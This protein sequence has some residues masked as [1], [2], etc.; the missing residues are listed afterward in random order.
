MYHVTF[1]TRNAT[2]IGKQRFPG[3]N[4]EKPLLW[5]AALVAVALNTV[6]AECQQ[7][8]IE[9][10]TGKQIVL[11]QAD[12]EALPHTKVTTHASDTPATFEGITLNDLLGKAGIEFGQ[13][14]KDKRLASCLLVGAADRYRV[15]IALPELD[16]AFTDKQIVLFCET[17]SHW[18][19]KR[20]RTALS[21]PMVVK[22]M[23][24]WVRQVATLKIVEVKWCD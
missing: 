4:H 17:E 18:T 5:C 22:R 10:E 6:P 7:L 21:Y 3:F 24:R 15:V 12:I 1:C 20:R 2:Q 13:T 14:L 19:Q 16:P 8:S 23:A 9:P 11:E